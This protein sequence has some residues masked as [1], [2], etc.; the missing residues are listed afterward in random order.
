MSNIDIIV[1]GTFGSPIGFQQNSKG[2]NK[3]RTFDL[4]TNAIKIYP[5]SVLYS[6]RNEINVGP[7]VLSY[8][9]YSY[10]KEK[11]SD[12]SGTFIGSSLS[13]NNSI[14]SE[15]QILDV[16]NDFHRLLI[17][18]KNN[19]DES[20]IQVNSV[21]ELKI[22]VNQK[23][24]ELLTENQIPIVEI[25]NT[26]T[27]KDLVVYIDNDFNTLSLLLSESKK[28]LNLYNTIYFTNS[29]EIA[30]FV[31]EKRIFKI[32]DIKGFYQENENY[33]KYEEEEYQKRFNKGLE[34]LSNIKSE[35]EI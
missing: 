19:I 14:P 27:N 4:N 33:L 11:N 7:S 35:I 30:K 2:K 15:I 16:L 22:L 9:I 12:R 24:L 21:N 31:Q 5:N 25:S 10:A 32:V 8:S 29:S 17:N 20:V 6:I 3:Y 26:N 23:K 1:F 28:L 18:D 34:S 13:F